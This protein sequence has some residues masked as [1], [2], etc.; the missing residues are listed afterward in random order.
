M[1]LRATEVLELR[2][3]AMGVRGAAVIEEIEAAIT[4]DRGGLQKGCLLCSSGAK[5]CVQRPS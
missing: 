1:G 3:C 2:F 5:N 4:C